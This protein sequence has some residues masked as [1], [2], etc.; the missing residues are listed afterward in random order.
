MESSEADI[1]HSQSFLTHYYNY[2]IGVW[3]WIEFASLLTYW[4]L[5]GL[6]LIV[7]TPQLFLASN[8]DFIA[9]LHQIVKWFQGPLQLTK[10][11]IKLEQGQ[12]QCG[13]AWGCLCGVFSVIHLN[14][15]WQLARLNTII[16]SSMQRIIIQLC[17]DLCTSSATL[18]L[19]HVPSYGPS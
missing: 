13:S 5:Y 15:I 14:E 7:Y 8:F 11:R 4:T 12:L 16:Y 10:A 17:C 1:L 18:Y 9:V 19:F 3:D 2:F 6:T